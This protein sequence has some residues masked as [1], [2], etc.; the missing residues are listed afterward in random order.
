M[1]TEGL[2]AYL[3]G[4]CVVVFRFVQ[5]LCELCWI[6]DAP[7][8]IP[9]SSE[10]QQWVGELEQLLTL[11]TESCQR[12]WSDHVPP[13]VVITSTGEVGMRDVL[14]TLLDH[15]GSEDNLRVSIQVLTINVRHLAYTLYKHTNRSIL[16]TK[17]LRPLS[18]RLASTGTHTVYSVFIHIQ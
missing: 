4:T 8:P 1:R 18:S 12:L 16:C 10:L 14:K 7:K 9:S 5:E 3:T 6:A 17:V 2:L 11:A 15:C 13:P